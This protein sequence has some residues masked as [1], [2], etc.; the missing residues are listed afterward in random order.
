MQKTWPKR[1]EGAATQ[2]SGDNL[3]R[4]LTTLELGQPSHLSPTGNSIKTPPHTGVPDRCRRPPQPFF[5]V[6]FRQQSRKPHLLA[7]AG[8]GLCRKPQQY[9]LASRPIHTTNSRQCSPS[10]HGVRLLSSRS[11]ARTLMTDDWATSLVSHAYRCASTTQPFSVGKPFRR[12]ENNNYEQSNVL[13]RLPIWLPMF[14]W[15]TIIAPLIL[16]PFHSHILNFSP[17]FMYVGVHLRMPFLAGAG[18]CCV[19]EEPR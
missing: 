10:A 9:R 8:V 19:L 17:L 15:T 5:L 18:S 4:P 14:P 11:C 16:L 1:R 7:V 6:P 3:L 2:A 13:K 12:R